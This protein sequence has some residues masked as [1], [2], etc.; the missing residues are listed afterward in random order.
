MGCPAFHDELEAVSKVMPSID[1]SVSLTKIVV[2][3]RGGFCFEINSAFAWMLR[4]LGYNVRI[5]LSHV[6]T[7]GGPVPGHLCLLVDGL[8][9]ACA[10]L[11]DPG[12]GDAPRVPI[13]LS[14]KGVDAAV[15]D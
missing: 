8:D 6:M 4:K 14:I 3:R 2:E 11:V 12:F 1:V 10:L 13:P 7:P 9:P 5:S 15:D